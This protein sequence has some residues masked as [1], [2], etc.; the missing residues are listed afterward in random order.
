MSYY[1]YNKKR[2]YLIVDRV[3]YI[4]N[5]FF[6]S[7]IPPVIVHFYYLYNKVKIIT[8]NRI[9][10]KNKDISLFVIIS[11]P[12]YSR[13]NALTPIK[14]IGLYFTIIFTFFIYFFTY[15]FRQIYLIN[16]KKTNF[17]CL[18][19]VHLNILMPHEL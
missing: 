7:T 12:S 18:L 3:R 9:I 14:Y 1:S 11:P 10:I 5:I 4:P 17:I 16:Y 6:E 13:R 2:I 19:F 15:K 8:N